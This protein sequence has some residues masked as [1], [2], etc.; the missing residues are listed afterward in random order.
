MQNIGIIL[1][2]VVV[3]AIGGYLLIGSSATP[4]AVVMDSTT[5]EATADRVVTT[6]E[7]ME[8]DIVATAASNEDFA[9]L[10]TA[11]IAAELAETLQG[12]GPFTVFAPVNEAFAALP[13]GTV[14]TLL[15]PENISDLQAVLTYHVVAGDVRSNNLFDGMVVETVNGAT[16]TIGVSDAGVTVND[17]NVVVA[18]IETSNGVIHVIDSVIL[19]PTE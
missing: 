11:V 14:E 4:E 18:D 15:L 2:V 16:I 10:V 13:A 1:A 17:A 9:T 3:A 8:M 19:P 6:P 5:G 7:T 12:P